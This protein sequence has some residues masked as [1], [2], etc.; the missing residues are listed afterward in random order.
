MKHIFCT[1]LLLTY[2]IT[3]TQ[4]VPTGGPGN[5]SVY[6]IYSSGSFLFAGTENGAVFRSSNNG[7]TWEQ[8]ISG[9]GVQRVNQ[10]EGNN[11]TLFAGGLNGL[12]SSTN[13]GD[14]WTQVNYGENAEVTAVRVYG[15]EIFAGNYNGG[16]FKSTNN[17]AN[18]ISIPGINGTIRSIIIAENNLFVAASGVYGSSNGGVNWVHEYISGPSILMR[19]FYYYNNVLRV[20]TGN[21]GKKK[22]GVLNG[23]TTDIPWINYTWGYAS[24]GSYILAG[25]SNGIFWS[26]NFGATWN[27][28]T[29]SYMISI[30][31]TSMGQNN[32]YLFA[33]SNS[34]FVY[35]R[36]ITQFTGLN[37]SGNIVPANYYLSQNYP[38]PFNPVTNIK[39]GVPANSFVTLK[40]FNEIG[41]EIITAVS[42]GLAAGEYEYNFDAGKLS[43]G[44]YYYRLTTG[45][46][47]HT[48]KMI[49]V[50]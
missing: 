22:T 43:S 17:G 13:N 25:M 21:G 29:S 7:D 15:N 18:W 38:N 20:G 23:W 32:Q 50:K 9:M 10:I 26:S 2:S 31:V 14:N 19:S 28:P 27:D 44:I 4:F 42:S 34:G 47:S 46:F 12:F 45:E 11:S 40:I 5:G 36:P 16:L 3:Y 30:Y 35:R 37:Q 1:L 24:T 49:L 41:Q 6:S 48:K 8:K 39:F 33:G